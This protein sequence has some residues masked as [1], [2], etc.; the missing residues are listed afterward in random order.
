MEEEEEGEDREAQLGAVG[1][2]DDAEGSPP[3]RFIF[4]RQLLEG[5]SKFGLA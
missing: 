2:F 5:M 3:D 4:E 1:A